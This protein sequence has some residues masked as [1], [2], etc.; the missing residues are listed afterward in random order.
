MSTATRRRPSR[1]FGNE[2]TTVL[3]FSDGLII[4]TRDCPEGIP[5][6]GHWVAAGTCLCTAHS[7]QIAAAAET[8]GSAVVRRRLADLALERHTA[9]Q[10]ALAVLEP[11]PHCCAICGVKC[12]GRWCSEPC[13]EA[14]E[15]PAE[16]EL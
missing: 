9:E 4:N 13:R 2:A 16:V 10:Q 12:F 8:A 11:L 15:G 1:S 6:R 3:R 14:D 7:T 5:A